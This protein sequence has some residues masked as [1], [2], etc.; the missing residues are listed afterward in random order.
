MTD[1]LILKDLMTSNSECINKLTIEVC[2]L[3][4]I[5]H[6]LRNSERTSLFS[7]ID[8]IKDEIGVL[9]AAT[10]KAVDD[11]KEAYKKHQDS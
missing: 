2:H 10:I 4:D 8:R 1:Y 6:L 5:T 11:Y 7:T 9:M 3:Y